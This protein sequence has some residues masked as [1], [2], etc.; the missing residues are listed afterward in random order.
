M[1]YLLLRYC[2]IF[3]LIALH[4]GASSPN[5]KLSWPTP[6]PAFA[7]GLGYST[8]LQKTGPDKAVTSGAYGCVRNNGYKFHEGLD[9]YPVKRDRRGKAEDS[10]YA[11]MDGVVSYVNSTASYS[12]YGK[13]IV[14]EHPQLNP[15]LYSLYA[16][17]HSI[18]PNLKRGSRIVIA[19]EIG[20]M[21]N[22][23]SGYR[24]PLER[25]HLHFEMGLRLTD[26]F[27]N[28]YN[29][30]PFTS[31]NRHDNFSG[32]NL[33]GLDPLAFYTKYKNKSISNPIDF[34]RALPVTVIVQV[35]TKNIPD[36]ITRYPTLTT[37]TK[38]TATNGWT[39]SFGPYGIPLQ[40][41]PVEEMI[42]EKEKQIKIL[43]FNSN[44]QKKPCR[45]LT[46][47]KGSEFFP[48]EQLQTYLELIF[49]L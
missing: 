18:T 21:G 36:F 33:V 16:H 15:P 7:R 24:I 19:Q 20:K 27:Q 28:W 40:L 39:V 35:K 3:F 42:S 29:K 17:L 48:T 10:I 12:A 22:S 23:S 45:R 41:K 46:T 25:S 44:T 13:Y 9:L 43:Q 32:F 8:F 31:K 49:G 14:L 6:N 30:K 37:Q 34:I 2:G 4:L 1:N 38:S 5:F 47:Q 26:K 11:A